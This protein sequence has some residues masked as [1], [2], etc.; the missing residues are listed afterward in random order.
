M[1]ARFKWLILPT[2]IL[3]SAAAAFFY[4]Q[5]KYKDKTGV[6]DFQLTDLTG[7]LI[8]LHGLSGKKAVVLIAHVSGCPHIEESVPELKL[9]RDQYE[10]SGVS[11][12]LIN[13][14]LEDD[15][16]SLKQKAKDLSIDIPILKDDTPLTA[17]KLRLTRASETIVLVPPHWHGSWAVA[18]RG[19]IDDRSEFGFDHSTPNHFYLKDALASIVSGRPVKVSETTAK[20]CFINYSDK[21]DF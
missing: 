3:A 21:H 5:A 7:N 20:G 18:Y 1:G 8:D 11:F 2:T 15:R 6:E 10:H 19:A 12:F 4:T 17:K 9:L 14:T 16:A 13:A